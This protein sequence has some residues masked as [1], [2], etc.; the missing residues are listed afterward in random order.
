MLYLYTGTDR[1]KA[2]SVMQKEI[3]KVEKG[4]EV[5]RV[6]DAHTVEDLRAALQGRG[7]FGGPRV[8]VLEGALSHDEMHVIVFEAL[9]SLQ[10]DSDI[11]FIYEEKV[12]AATRKKIEKYAEKSERFD[13]GKSARDNEAFELAYAL[14]QGDKKKLWVGYMRELGKGSAPEMIHGILFWAAKQ[15]FMRVSR[16]EDKKR[17]A[18]VMMQLVELPHEARRKGFDMEYAL[19]KFVLSVA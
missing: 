15:N 1:E 19:E 14:Q 9:E 8:V 7:M 4:R 17:A 3:A 16:E 12:D 18:K 5:I 2:R 6:T 11:F 13:A 10:N